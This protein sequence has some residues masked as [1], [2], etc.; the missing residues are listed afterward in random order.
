MEP[1]RLPLRSLVYAAMFAALT[2]VGAFFSIPLYPVPITLQN[3]FTTLSGLLLGAYAGALSQIAYILVGLSGLPVF[4]GGKAG[5]G[6]LLGPTGGYLIGFVLGAFTMGK[7]AAMRKKP[8]VWWLLFSALAGHVVIY[9]AGTTWLSLVAH[10]SL[11]KALAVGLLPFIPGDT[12]KCVAAAL[13]AR[14]IRA[15]WHLPGDDRPRSIADQ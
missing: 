15:H 12:L 5:L 2:G 8:A 13:I 9:G 4:S 3:L 1:K 14:K 6:V 11:K 10:I 7:L